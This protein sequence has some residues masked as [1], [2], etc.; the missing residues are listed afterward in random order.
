MYYNYNVLILFASA[1]A[2]R[3]NNFTARCSDEQIDAKVK[4]WF[5]LTGIET[6]GAR[7]ENQRR[8]AACQLLVLMKLMIDYLLSLVTRS[9]CDLY[10]SC[11]IS[12][13]ATLSAL[14]TIL[15][16]Y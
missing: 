4:R 5:Q 13:G 7:L 15:V 12:C 6:V 14:S 3:K 8:K 2:V 10:F 11:F 9:S 16:Y 1:G